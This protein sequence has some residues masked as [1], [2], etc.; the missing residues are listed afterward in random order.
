MSTFTE[1]RE[2]KAQIAA[3]KKAGKSTQTIGRLQYKLNQLSKDSKGTAV[4]TKSGVVKTKTGVLRQTDSSK[5]KR[6]VAK[7][8][9]PLTGHPNATTVVKAA[10]KATPKVTSTKKVVNNGSPHRGNK[11]GTTNPNLGGSVVRKRNE[12]IKK[13]TASSSNV[14]VTPLASTKITKSKTPSTGT[15]PSYTFN[16]KED[17]S[18]VP[19][20]TGKLP[21]KKFQTKREQ[22]EAFRRRLNK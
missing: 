14:T 20:I 6:V 16:M 9:S 7:R 10:P 19:R 21:E 2:L 22:L 17:Y 13:K 1:K 8:T 3:A 11:A 18:K 4:K 12:P 15:S 5:K